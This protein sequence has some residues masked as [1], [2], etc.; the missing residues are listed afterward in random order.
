MAKCTLTGGGGFKAA[1]VEIGPAEKFMSEAGA[2]YRTSDN[3]D[4]Q[5]TTRTRSA[6]GLFGGIK[7]MFAGE[8]F[9]LSEY[10]TTDGRGGEVGLAPT[11]PGDVALIQCNGQSSWICTGGSYIGS[12]ENL[13]LDT[14]FQGLR[15]M[16]SGESLSFLKVDGVGELLVSAFGA[17]REIDVDGAFTV[18]TG[19]VVA[20][21][22]TLTYSLGKAGG[23]WLQSFLAS[24][25]I[26]LNFSGRGKLYVQSHNP[27]EWG[28]TLGGLLPERKQ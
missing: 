28:G 13:S 2:M 9:F 5:V 3:V 26:T 20:F 10:R 17:I 1:L 19:H 14:E 18:D 24:E 6:G 22:D 21:E 11:L 12:S 25:G 7:R 15:G 23:S 16:F 4:V 27:S 8:S